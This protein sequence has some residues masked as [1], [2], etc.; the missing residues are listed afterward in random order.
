MDTNKHKL[1][2][3]LCNN[4]EKRYPGLSKKRLHVS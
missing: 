4:I 1:F 2:F 3:V